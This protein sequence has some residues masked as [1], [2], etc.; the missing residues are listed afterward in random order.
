MNQPL[1]PARIDWGISL[2]LASLAIACFGLG[3]IS[4]FLPPPSIVGGIFLLLTGALL[5]SIWMRTYYQVD[6]E[7]VRIQC[8]PLWWNIPLE[9]IYFVEK[10]SS[11][12][13]MM[14]GPHLRF[15]LSR[16]GLMIRYRRHTSHKWL[17]IF[18]PSVLIS[19]LDRDQFLAS[20]HTARPD[21]TMSQGGERL[22][23]A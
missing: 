6:Q 10:T 2:L 19:P 22:G 11:V 3:I 20:I 9:Q 23:R 17:G 14:G 18:D 12:W 13:L 21:L 16:R 15:A 8:G 1:F 4:L 5:Q 7:R